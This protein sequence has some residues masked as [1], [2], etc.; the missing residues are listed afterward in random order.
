MKKG[1]QRQLNLDF[2]L[3]N[4]GMIYRENITVLVGKPRPSYLLSS[5][6]FHHP[7]KRFSGN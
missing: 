5:F 1:F 7:L 2:Y 4:H 6:G 3:R